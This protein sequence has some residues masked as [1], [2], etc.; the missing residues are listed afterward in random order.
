M[1]MTSQSVCGATIDIDDV[2]KSFDERRVLSHIN[3]HVRSGEFVAVVGRSGSGKS[4]LLRLL[5]GLEQPTQGSSR[6][7]AAGGGEAR[8]GVRVVFQEPRLLPWKSVLANVCLGI[9]AQGGAEQ[10]ARDA[11]GRRVLAAVG[12]ADRAE[13]YPS[14]LSGG[15]RQRVALA[16]ALLHEPSVMLLDEPFGALDALTRIEAQRLV[17]SL[18]LERGFTALLVTHDVS[19]AVLLADR[20]LLI[21]D[22]TIAETFEVPLP[23][24]RRRDD[25]ELTRLA[26]SILERIFSAAG[27]VSTR[28]P[29]E[30]ASDAETSTISRVGAKP[31]H[32]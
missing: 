17:E 14:V 8:G 6:V 19:E 31:A 16:R 15:Q 18:W 12:L 22:G 10:R 27:A 20:V 4:T 25:V 7:M 21:A 9:P 32:A 11:A 26:A 13:E 29:C 5:C 24:P 30:S 23:R 28:A 3:L 1:P 2:A